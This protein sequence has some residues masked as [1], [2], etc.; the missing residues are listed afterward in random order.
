MLF[1]VAAALSGLLAIASVCWVSPA[2]GHGN[3][4]RF[5]G[6]VGFRGFVAGLIYGAHYVY[7][8]RWVLEFPIIQ[9]SLLLLFH[10]LYF[11]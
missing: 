2:G 7:K 5:V 9:V 3:G 8:H 10:S 11:P 6:R 4:V 1:S